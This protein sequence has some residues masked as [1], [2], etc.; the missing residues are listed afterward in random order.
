MLVLSIA[1]SVATNLASRAGGWLAPTTEPPAPAPVRPEQVPIT[2]ETKQ[3]AEDAKTGV[4]EVSTQQQASDLDVWRGII[5]EAGERHCRK[6][7]T[8]GECRGAALDELQ[9]R[10]DSC[11]V[12]PGT[13]C[14]RSCGKALQLDMHY[15]RWP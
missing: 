14:A 3:A 5:A 7:S 15:R 9:R 13:T 8:E 6:G 10:I 12:Q 2:V 4:G 1:G 11:A